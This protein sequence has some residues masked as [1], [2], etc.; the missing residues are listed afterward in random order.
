MRKITLGLALCS[1]ALA[2]PAVAKDDSAYVEFGFGPMHLNDF[3]LTEVNPATGDQVTLESDYGFDGTAILGYDYGAF[4]VELEASY[5]QADH[6]SLITPFGTFGSGRL[7]G[8]SSAASLMGN[9]L[10]DFGD[11]DGLQAFVGAGAGSAIVD[12]SIAITAPGGQQNLVNGDE[13][14]FAWQALAGVRAPLTD[15]IDVGLRYRFFN[16][17]DYEL[18]GSFGTSVV[19]GDWSSH[20]ILGTLAFNFG[21][22]PPPPPPPP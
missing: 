15:T 14:E 9:V 3:D 12:Q 20:S 13:W 7:L 17:P 22:P 4:R 18:G 6:E 10:L 1:T 5:R 21:A 2:A 11:D 8:D 19:E 16:V